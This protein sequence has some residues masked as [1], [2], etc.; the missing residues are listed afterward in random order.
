MIS[1]SHGFLVTAEL[2]G[3]PWGIAGR[4]KWS[5]CCPTNSAKSL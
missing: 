5:S 2:W 1:P 3:E 4:T